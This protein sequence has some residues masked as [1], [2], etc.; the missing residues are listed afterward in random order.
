MAEQRHNDAL[1][2]EEGSSVG[3]GGLLV[4]CGG[5]RERKDER[6][7]KREEGRQERGQGGE[8]YS[9]LRGALTCARSTL[10]PR[11]DAPT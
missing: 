2:E 7:R 8:A 6:G 11:D 10:L 3:V 4:R 5:R 1:C 9:P